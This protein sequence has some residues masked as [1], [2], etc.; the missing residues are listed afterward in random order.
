MSKKIFIFLFFISLSLFSSEVVERIVA[1]VNEDIITLSDIKKVDLNIRIALSSRFEGKELEEKLEEARKNLLEDLIQR[2]LL[3]AK[4]KEDGMDV[5][6]ETK[7]V[8]E[9]ILKENN[10]SSEKDLEE[11]M[12]EEGINYTTW[13]EELKKNLLQ[14]K[15]I[16]KYVDS[17]ISVDNAEMLDYYR[18]HPEE[19]TEPEEVKIKGIF[20]EEKEGVEER[21]KK[22]E[23]ELKSKSFEEVAEIY[24]EGPEK[25]KKGDLGTFKKGEMDKSLENHV[26]SMKV[27][28]LTQWI[29]TSKGYYILKLEEK[30]EAKL[31]SFEEARDEILE[32][33]IEIKREP[34]LKKFFDDLRAKSYIKILIPDPFKY[35]KEG[36]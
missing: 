25:E 23:E 32:K 1:I 2:K 22:I 36:E 34:L 33:I 10:L 5:E 16:R 35:L 28:E 4:A 7:M 15:V 18:K 12:K 31:K 20:L 26:F 21:M 8:I 30:K 9:N 6:S 24:S 29:K 27:G 19:F 13:K 3:L 17:N 14:Q 11:L